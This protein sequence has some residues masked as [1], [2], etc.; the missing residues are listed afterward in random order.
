M[1]YTVLDNS[2]IRRGSAQ[3]ILQQIINKE[4]DNVDIGQMTVQQ[5]AQALIDNAGYYLPKDAVDVVLDRGFPLF[6]RALNLLNA[7]PASG[8]HIIAS[9]D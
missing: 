3:D 1:K 2:T 5:Y 7:M 6:D 8:T 9:E 4:T